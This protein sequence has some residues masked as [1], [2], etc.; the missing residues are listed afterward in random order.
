MKV[1][2]LGR[3][4]AV[5]AIGSLALTACGSDNATGEGSGSTETSAADEMRADS[6]KLQVL[7]EKTGGDREPEAFAFLQAHLEESLAQEKS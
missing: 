4:A 3:S 6:R 1:S 5:L 2:H 7:V